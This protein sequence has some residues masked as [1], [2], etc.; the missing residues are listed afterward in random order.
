MLVALYGLPGAGKTHTARQ[1]AERHPLVVLSTDAVR[2]RYSLP[3]GPA[4]HAAILA[5]AGPL[6]RANAG[7]LFDGIHLGRHDRDEIR[8]FAAQ[9]GSVAVVVHVTACAPAIAQRLEERRRDR[10]ATAAQDKFVITRE[11][12]ERIAG[13]LEPVAP[14]EEVWVI[15]TS[16]GASDE[17]L[18]RLHDHLCV[19]RP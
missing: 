18:R 7:V 6:L 8:A 4:A 11:K 1:L 10:A 12:F 3:S 17:P 2:L 9:Q 5:A 15:D 16:P 14:D 13:F 19:L